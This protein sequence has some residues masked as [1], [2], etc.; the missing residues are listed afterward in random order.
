M[1][2]WEIDVEMRVRKTLHFGGPTDEP[3]ARRIAELA[4]AGGIDLS[5]IFKWTGPAH[6]PVP[7]ETVIDNDPQ[8]VAIRQINEAA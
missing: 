2:T 1:A 5:T 4:L 6:R 8:I 7:V 3:A